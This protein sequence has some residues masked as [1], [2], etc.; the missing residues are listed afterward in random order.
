[1]KYIKPIKR[2]D[3]WN[4][5]YCELWDFSQA[6]S[7]EA[8]RR[9][10]I[11]EIAKVCRDKEDLPDKLYDH[12]L[13]EHAGKPGELFQFIPILHAPLT[14]M[15]YVPN[16]VRF[17]YKF[18]KYKGLPN[19][20]LT[21]LRALLETPEICN[22]YQEQDSSKGFYVFKCKIPLMIVPQILRHGQLSFMQQSERH[23]KLR[24]YYYCDELSPIMEKEGKINCYEDSTW[25]AVCL[26]LSQYDLDRYQSLYRL[27]QELT[28]KGSHG[29]AY[30]TLWIAGWKQD[31]SQWINFFSVRLE[32]KTQKELR[33]LAETMKQLMETK[34]EEVNSV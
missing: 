26:G 17:G 2:I 8:A 11:L 14:R 32:K 22:Y 10:T 13:I 27:R 6:N 7:C 1:M 3:L 16:T 9:E 33:E 24:E 23:C 4:S 25:N 31:P 28:N 19:L 34:Q 20:Y 29:L 30:T 12:L 5:G 15:G 21:N 18:E